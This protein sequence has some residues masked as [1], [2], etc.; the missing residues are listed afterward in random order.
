MLFNIV[1]LFHILK[2]NIDKETKTQYVK[3]PNILILQIRVI[4]KII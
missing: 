2:T 3:Y 1:I 4:N